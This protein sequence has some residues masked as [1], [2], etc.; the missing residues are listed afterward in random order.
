[1]ED[2]FIIHKLNNIFFNIFENIKK[3]YKEE[4]KI[5]KVSQP[6]QPT[7]PEIDAKKLADAVNGRFISPN[8]ARKIFAEGRRVKQLTRGNNLQGNAKK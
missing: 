3:K 8:S 1:M 2:P 5:Q 7:Q 4:T 6:G